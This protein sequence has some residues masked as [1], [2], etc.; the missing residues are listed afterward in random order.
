[1]EHEHITADQAF[2]ILRRASQHLNEKLDVGRTLVETGQA[3]DGGD[4]PRSVRMARSP[5]AAS[6]SC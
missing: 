3:P 1:M 2:A 5:P 4:E 6:L